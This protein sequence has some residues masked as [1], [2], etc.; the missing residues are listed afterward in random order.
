[1]ASLTLNPLQIALFMDER[2]NRMHVAINERL[3]NNYR[4]DA[5]H[6]LFGGY[7]TCKKELVYSPL[8]SLLPI[9]HHHHHLKLYSPEQQYAISGM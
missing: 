9:H 7:Y 5:N 6:G 8:P 3:L 1:M 2:W 4:W